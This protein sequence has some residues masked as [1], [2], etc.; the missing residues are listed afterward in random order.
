MGR[1]IA[2]QIDMLWACVLFYQARPRL[3]FVPP[4]EPY[5]ESGKLHCAASES[6]DVNHDAAKSAP[7]KPEEPMFPR[8]NEP[9]SGGGAV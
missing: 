4:D 5:R 8:G 6:G 1:A 2:M 7:E 3:K 9:G